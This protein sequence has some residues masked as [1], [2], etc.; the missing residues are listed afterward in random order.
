MQN[1]YAYVSMRLDAL[2]SFTVNSSSHLCHFRNAIFKAK[3][4]RLCLEE[5]TTTRGKLHYHM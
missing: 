5:A 4:L 2:V 1:S 3:H